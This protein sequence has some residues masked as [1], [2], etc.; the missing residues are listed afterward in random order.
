MTCLRHS[1]DG[2][3]ILVGSLRPVSTPRVTPTSAAETSATVNTIVMSVDFMIT[4]IG[5]LKKNCGAVDKRD[6]AGVL[7]NLACYT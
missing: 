6:K 1:P 7:A 4:E 2:I 3:V 5:A